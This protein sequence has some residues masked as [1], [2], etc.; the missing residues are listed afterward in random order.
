MKMVK[1]VLFGAV[2]LAAILSLVSCGKKNDTEKAIKGSGDNWTVD[3]T[4]D[5]T[6]NY[7]AYRSTG[8][9][10]AGAIVKVTFNKDGDPEKSKMGVIFGLEEKDGKSNFNLI[11]LAA[12]GTYYVSTFKNIEDIQA[13]NF[14]A[15]PNA[16]SGPTEK[17]WV[18]LDDGEKVTLK[19]DGNG[20]KYTYV[21]YRA[22]ATGQYQ[23]M[24]GDLSE[25]N[26]NAFDSNTGSF[27]TSE[28]SVLTSV[29]TA[30]GAYDEIDDAF[31]PTTNVPQHQIS[32]YA[33]IRPGKHLVGS[34]NVA[35]KYKEAEDIE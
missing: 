29:L 28:T 26:L 23:W 1:K 35:K 20:N 32:F 21:M 7:R 14:G 3:Y 13:N 10:H 17:E 18:P 30:G 25:A 16:A 2:A 9:K 4:N 33:M 6:E 31:E 15:T 24:I 27:G 22:V 11:G 34:W 5:A 19:D 8:L 12:D